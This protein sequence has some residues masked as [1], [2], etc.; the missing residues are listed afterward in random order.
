MTPLEE[1]NWCEEEKP[2]EGNEPIQS[3][4]ADGIHRKVGLDPGNYGDLWTCL[5][6]CNTFESIM[7]DRIRFITWNCCIGDFR[8]KSK[9]I[10]LL[11]PDVLV[12]QEVEPIDQVLLYGGENN[13]P[14][15]AKSGI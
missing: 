8:C 7:A 4:A 14:F 12:L 1:W 13:P 6:V 15:V 2:D 5:C 9:Q 11:K 3:E 10:A